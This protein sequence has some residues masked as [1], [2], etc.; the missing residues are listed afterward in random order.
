MFGRI[1]SRPK[2][3]PSG[4]VWLA[5]N[6]QGGVS[7]PNQ[8]DYPFSFHLFLRSGHEPRTSCYCY[9]HCYFP[10]TPFAFYSTVIRSIAF[11]IK[12]TTIKPVGIESH[13]ST[14]KYLKNHTCKKSAVHP[15]LVNNKPKVIVADIAMETRNV[16]TIIDCTLDNFL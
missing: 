12:G 15:V 3:P 8:V 2:F 13:N 10:H 5:V 14:R 4:G 16:N 11:F 9:C 7:T 6:W 1:L